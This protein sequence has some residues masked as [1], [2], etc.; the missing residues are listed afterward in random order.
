MRGTTGFDDDEYIYVYI[1]IYIYILIIY[2]YIES[3]SELA[4][5]KWYE[6]TSTHRRLP[7]F[8]IKLE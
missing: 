6:L 8:A 3:T 1:Y 2:R 5:R 4:V 7:E